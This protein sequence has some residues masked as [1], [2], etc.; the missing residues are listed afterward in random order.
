M[1]TKA[2]PTPRKRTPRKKSAAPSVLHVGFAWDMSG[3]MAA[4][5]DASIEGTRGYLADLQT[6]EQKIVAE[7]GEGVYTYLTV[8][9]FDTVL[10]RWMDGVPA[11]DLDL[12]TPDRYQ[13][14]GGTALYD[15]IADTV[16]AMD[17]RVKSDEKVLV[18]VMTDGYENSSKEYGGV[19]GRQRIF[20]MVHAY[21]ARGNWTFVYLGANV[22]AYAEAASMGISAGNA[23]FYS[24][25]GG[26]V[27][28]ASSG[29]TNVTS[30]LRS[31]SMGGSANTFADAGETQDYRDDNTGGDAHEHPWML[32][33]VCL[34][35]LLRQRI[36]HT[37]GSC[38]E[39]LASTYAALVAERLR[40]RRLGRDASPGLIRTEWRALGPPFCM[41]VRRHHPGAPVVT[42]R[43]RRAYRLRRREGPS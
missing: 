21:E 3:S 19:G 39:A 5:K 10:E 34:P 7:H 11:A 23:A 35:E 8:T 31:A 32:D 2:T 12:S 28:M 17:T 20:D 36:R 16:T 18:V 15:A 41:I 43:R 25:T 24:A 13:P 42:R 6:E 1:A 4:I 22:D 29:L 33:D 26:S 40:Q 27:A 14:R 38:S 37:L 30:T 9:A